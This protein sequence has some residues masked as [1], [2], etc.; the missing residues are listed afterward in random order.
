MNY[1]EAIKSVRLKMGLTQEEVCNR[2][3]LTQGFYSSVEH[4]NNVPGLGTLQ[5]ISD[6]FGLPMFFI[7]WIA[8]ERHSLSKKER[9]W[10]DNL[11]PVISAIMEELTT[12]K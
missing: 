8:T 10:Y 1:G 9:V 7:I 3:Q 12:S 2:A 4:G 6:A 11:S 5:R